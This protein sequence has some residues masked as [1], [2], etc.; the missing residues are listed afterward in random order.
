MT[1]MD[2][3]N[4]VSVPYDNDMMM[5]SVIVLPYS[6]QYCPGESAPFIPVMPVSPATRRYVE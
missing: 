6:A 1:I 3:V 2:Y 4:K 5:L